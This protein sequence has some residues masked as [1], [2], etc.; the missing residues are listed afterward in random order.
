MKTNYIIFAGMLRTGGYKDVY[1]GNNGMLRG[2]KYN[3][4]VNDDGYTVTNDES[5]SI[6]IVDNMVEV[7]GR[8]GHN[9]LFPITPS[10]Q[11]KELTSITYDAIRYLEEEAK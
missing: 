6:N 11:M 9:V 2:F 7:Y 10:M 4:E 8:L 3:L 1:V 5:I